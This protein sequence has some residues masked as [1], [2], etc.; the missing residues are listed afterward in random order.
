MTTEH[1]LPPLPEHLAEVLRRI[2]ELEPDEQWEVFESL[3]V[4][5]KLNLPD[6]SRRQGLADLFLRL[7]SLETARH[8]AREM[9][10]QGR[11]T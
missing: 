3:L 4:Q 9:Q 5:L 6:P 8:R 7:T 11:S 2:E 1:V 10:K